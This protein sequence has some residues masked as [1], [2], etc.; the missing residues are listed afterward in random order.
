MTGRE[1]IEA[2]FSKNGAQEIPA[3]ICYESILIRDHWDEFTSCPWWYQFEYEID[4]QLCWY[5][6]YLSAVGQDWFFLPEFYSRKE[7]E[8]M[9]LEQRTDGIYRL[10]RQTGA[11]EKLIR[12]EIGGGGGTEGA[13][14]HPE[15]MADTVAEVDR[16]V[17][18]YAYQLAEGM[19]DLSHELVQE[20][21]NGLFPMGHIGSPYRMCYE[22]WGF[23]GLMMVIGTN[24]ELVE[25]ACGR[26]LD[27]AFKQAESYSMAGAAGIWIEE[28]FADMISP[29]ALDQLCLK[30]VKQLIDKIHDCGMKS[31]YYF[32]GNPDG[33]Y[34]QLIAT[35]TDALAFEEGKK[36]FTSDIGQIAEIVNG[37]C[38]LLGNLDAI[39]FLQD[40]SD[41]E[42][43]HEID[44]QIQA[45][46][47][48]NNRFIMSIGSP[49][50]PST[51]VKRV[52]DYCEVAH[53]KG[54]AGIVTHK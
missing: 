33:R 45:G 51:S 44:R 37:R 43:Q 46:R 9:M 22:V 25:Y 17:E 40:S 11:G 4:R 1:K 19:H 2:A 48:N 34:E 41:E 14:R 6:D 21:G 18:K 38:T 24:P 5:K 52:R 31:V 49:V 39:A 12:P 3:V 23:E 35:G 10:N 29:A 20:Y 30:F 32:S 27:M 54:V 8:I 7:R 16:V 15:S 28:L 42:L 47:K 36:G 13:P 50:T 53:Q 26:F